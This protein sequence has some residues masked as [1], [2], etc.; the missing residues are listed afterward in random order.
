M[1]CNKSFYFFP[2]VVYEGVVG[3]SYL[4]DSALDDINVYE[5]DCARKYG[6]IIYDMTD[7]GC[8]KKCP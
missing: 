5:G 1:R 8:A 4:S 6:A 7:T 2:Q 3:S